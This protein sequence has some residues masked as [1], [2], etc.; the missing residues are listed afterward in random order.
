LAKTRP[1]AE[2]LEALKKEFG[3]KYHLLQE[4]T[5]LVFIQLKNDNLDEAVYSGTKSREVC[6]AV[7]KIVEAKREIRKIAKTASKTISTFQSNNLMYLY[8]KQKKAM[9]QENSGLKK[10]LSSEIIQRVLG[11]LTGVLEKTAIIRL[12]ETMVSGFFNSGKEKLKTRLERF[13]ENGLFTLQQCV[14]IES[15]K[16]EILQQENWLDALSEYLVF[17]VCRLKEELGF[18][19]SLIANILVKGYSYYWICDLYRQYPNLN[20]SFLDG[21]FCAEFPEKYLLCYCGPLNKEVEVARM[22]IKELTANANFSFPNQAE[23]LLKREYTCQQLVVLILNA[24]V[25]QSEE[26]INLGK[27][28]A[29]YF[30]QAHLYLSEEIAEKYRYRY[31]RNQCIQEGTTA[32]YQALESYVPDYQSGNGFPDH[33][34]RFINQRY[35]EVLKGE[36]KNY[37][38]QA[39]HFVNIDK[40]AYGDSSRATKQE[41]LNADDMIGDVKNNM[42]LLN[43]EDALIAREEN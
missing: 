21:M 17:N 36:R 43:P 27:Q 31:C 8:Q 20:R 39:Y 40:P 22:F 42:H 13:R 6:L 4:L 16:R 23:E 25:W 37:Q 2:I 29:R 14:L 12:A 32:L 19:D 10:Y 33:A 24:R 3:I 7:Y 38:N 9:A 15:D 26:D 35:E 34:R 18:S 5:D 28:A 30:V 1:D 41:T 11:Q